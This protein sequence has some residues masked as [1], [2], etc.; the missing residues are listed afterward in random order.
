MLEDIANHQVSAWKKKSVKAEFK[1]ELRNIELTK[2]RKNIWILTQMRM[3]TTADFL[4][5]LRNLAS[6]G[7]A[8]SKSELEHKLRN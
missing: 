3:K 8:H 6:C 2:K 5:R 7:I 4:A 1:N